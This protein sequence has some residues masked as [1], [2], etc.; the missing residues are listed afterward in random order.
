MCDSPQ[1]YKLD[2][3]DSFKELNILLKVD[4]VTNNVRNTPA[5]NILN[6]KNQDYYNKQDQPYIGRKYNGGLEQVALELV[7][8]IILEEEEDGFYQWVDK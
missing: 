5:T 2:S 6:K 4:D 3:L 1:N 8:D 7:P